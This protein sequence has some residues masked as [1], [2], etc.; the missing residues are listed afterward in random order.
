MYFATPLQ[1]NLN[2]TI[3]MSAEL[4][5]DGVIFWGDN[6]DDNSAEACSHLQ[7]YIKSALGPTVMM[8]QE[9]AESCSKRICSGKGRCVGDIL[10]CGS[11]RR[12]K[13]Y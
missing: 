13:G 4:G 7:S 8:S 11:S 9:G 12:R 10:T 5:V 3:L 6:L 2:D 1:E